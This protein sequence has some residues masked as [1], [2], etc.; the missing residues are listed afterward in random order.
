MC[1][2]IV[3]GDMQVR[4]LKKV[5]KLDEA[6]TWHRIDDFEQW[7]LDEGCDLNDPITSRFKKGSLFHRIPTDDNRKRL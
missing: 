5:N 1:F 3:K 4:L 2:G 7:V 6:K